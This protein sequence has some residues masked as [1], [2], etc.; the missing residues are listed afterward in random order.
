MKI[1]FTYFGEPTPKARAR[2]CRLKNGRVVSFTP[3]G[4]RDF[5][6]DLKHQAIQY[7]INYFERGTPLKVSFFIYRNR[8]ASIPKKVLFPVT[9]PDLTNYEKSIEDAVEKIVYENDSQICDKFARKRYGEPS[10]IEVIIE[11]LTDEEV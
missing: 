10:R 7:A 8:P 9:K 2:T 5:E 4:T 1:Q 3:K 6:A 11:N